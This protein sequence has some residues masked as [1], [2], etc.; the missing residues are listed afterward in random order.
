MEFI[1]YATIWEYPGVGL[2]MCGKWLEHQRFSSWYYRVEGYYC[3]TC[4]NID[5]YCVIMLEAGL[6]KV[7][8]L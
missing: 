6:S 1:Y 2:I 5:R 8:T 3:I 7:C 4:G